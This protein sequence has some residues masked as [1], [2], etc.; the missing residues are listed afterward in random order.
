V[1]ICEY[2]GKHFAYFSAGGK[3]RFFIHSLQ[4]TLR[5]FLKG[6]SQ[7]AIRAF[8]EYKSYRFHAGKNVS[9]LVNG[10]KLERP[11]VL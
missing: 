8:C 9:S 7:L 4:Q 1:V 5:K 3:F 11:A 6:F 2:R 10:K